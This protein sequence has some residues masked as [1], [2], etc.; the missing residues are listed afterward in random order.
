MSPDWIP[1]SKFTPAELSVRY[2]IP[3]EE[4][5]S[6]QD[7]TRI[8]PCGTLIINEGDSDKT[9][10][11]LRHGMVTVYKYIELEKQ[12]HIALIRAVNF[13]GEMS[14]LNDQPRSA[15]VE[16]YSEEAVVYAVDRPNVSLILGNPRWGELLLTRLSKDL[17]RTDNQLAAIMQTMLAMKQEK[18]SLEED[19]QAAR[20]EQQNLLEKLTRVIATL[21][22]FQRVIQDEAIVGS[23]GWVYLQAL[24]RLTGLLVSQALPELPHPDQ[25]PD[26]SLLRACLE[27]LGRKEPKSVYRNLLEAIDAP[28]S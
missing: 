22:E 23:R 21:A 6:F 25:A 27:E 8:Y 16:A 7:T 1:G 18:A 2:S 10:Y 3:R 5:E 13:F 4:A 15:T 26:R 24:N 11:L 20:L 28:R 17:A 19:L 14:L 12:E 9:L